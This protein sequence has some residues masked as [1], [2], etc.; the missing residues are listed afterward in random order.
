MNY[1]F[2]DFEVTP[3]WWLCVVGDYPED[4]KIPE[5]IK[6]DFHVFTSDMPDAATALFKC[7]ISPENVN[8]G[9]NIKR[10]DNLILKA[11]FNRLTPHQIHVI[12]DIVINHTEDI[13]A[14]HARLS[15]FARGGYRNKDFI[16]Q[17][18][19]DDNVGSLKQKES[20]M[21]L[22]IRE[23]TVPFTKEDLTDE[24]KQELI[25]Y[26]KHDV[27]SSMYYYNYV[28]KPFVDTKL[29][30]GK[31]FN[32]APA[33][34]YKSTNAGLSGIVLEA[35]KSTFPD[36]LRSDIELPKPI[37]DYLKYTLPASLVERLCKSGD[38]FDIQ[39]YGNKVSFGNGGTHSAPEDNVVYESND[40]WVLLNLDGTSFYPSLMIAWKTLSR[41]VKNPERFKEMFLAR[42]GFKKVIE[43]FEEKYGKEVW[44][45]PKEEY[46]HYHYC[47][48]T[49]Q[50]YKLILNTTYGASGNKWLALYDPYM[51]TKTCRIGQLMI[52]ALGNAIY[53]GLGKENVAIVQTNTDGIAIYMRRACMDTL[54]AI[55]DVWSSVSQVG[56]EIEEEKKIWQKNVSNYILLKRSGRTKTKGSFFVTDTIQPGYNRLRP[57]DCYTVRGAIMALLT[58]NR[59]PMD[60][61][62]KDTELKNFVISCDK[63]SY[64]G[65]AKR[66]GD[67]WMP[68]MKCNRVFATT[69]KSSGEVRL[70]KNFKGETRYYKCPGAPEHPELINAALDSYDFN[71]IKKRIDYM[72][73]INE[74][75]RLMNEPWY[76][77]TNLNRIE[78][79]PVEALVS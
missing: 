57:L 23:T 32:I 52:A 38:K 45:A 68:L 5:S 78:F 50:A 41:A 67:D 34:C 30:V 49:S 31:T 22:D 58:E 73:Y 19:L 6:D 16:Y 39:L 56:L 17:D 25:F 63:G 11:V 76:D 55:C 66:V 9:Y 64:G 74:V 70:M 71:D 77:L 60:Y 54:N 12:N 36:A 51:T 53:N 62:V 40:E 10:Y 28:I 26:C 59:N 72:W 4:G 35:T 27:W 75:I 8:F 44:R 15:S 24:E 14:E 1:K 47:K 65:I 46:E 18:L 20:C 48:E 21:G 37:A 61:I 3:N 42:V 2:F 43:P 7:M 13:D 29:L 33:A 69:D 79:N